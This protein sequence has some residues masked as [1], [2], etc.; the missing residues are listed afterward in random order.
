MEKVKYT[1]EKAEYQSDGLFYDWKEVRLRDVIV[2]EG[3]FFITRW[4][5]ENEMAYYPERKRISPYPSHNEGEKFYHIR[6]GISI[7]V[8]MDIPEEWIKKLL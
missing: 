5:S 7:S 2:E 4:V 8:K 1:V 3:D 6:N